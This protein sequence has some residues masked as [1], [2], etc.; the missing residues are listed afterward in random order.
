MI[1][2]TISRRTAA[3]FA[4]LAALL[5]L[6]GFVAGCSKFSEPFRDAPV[7]GRVENGAVI[8]TMPDGFNNWASKCDGHGH[9]V[10][11]TY[12][13]NGP[14]GGIAVIDDQACR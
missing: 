11:T 1:T 6:L 14:Y 10:F 3:I 12:H 13:N 4:A 8:G 5:V 9:R 7:I 2:I